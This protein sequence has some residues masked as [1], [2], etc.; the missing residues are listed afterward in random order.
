MISIKKD[1][2]NIPPRLASD[3]CRQQLLLALAEKNKHL[4]KGYYYRDGCRPL[5]EVSYYHKCGLCETKVGAAT[6][7]R[8][9]HYR[10]KKRVHGLVMHKGYYWLG[11]EW[12][13]LIFICDRCN[14]KKFDHFPIEDESHRLSSPPVLGNGDIDFFS[15]VLDTAILQNERA[16]ILHPEL[17]TPEKHF[18]FLPNG[19]IKGITNNGKTTIEKCGLNRQELTLAR[20]KKIDKIHRRLHNCLSRFEKQIISK[21]TFLSHLTEIFEDV[22]EMKFPSEEYSRLGFFMFIKFDLFFIQPLG[23]KQQKIVSHAFQ[24]FLNGKI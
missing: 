19:E 13:N 9:D 6:V 17:D 22:R 5:L 20:K 21:P 1:F 7:G 2:D 24:F 12:S 3:N 16:L 15:F 8:V 11:Y 23:P 18:I 10:P 14:N 4:F